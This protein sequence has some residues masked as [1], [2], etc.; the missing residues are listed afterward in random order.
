MAAGRGD[1]VVGGQCRGAASVAPRAPLLC[2]PRV[3]Q[4]SVGR[5]GAHPGGLEQRAALFQ[6][7]GD[8]LARLQLPGGGLR[9]SRSRRHASI[10]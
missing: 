3:D 7:G 2:Q 6:L 9:Q 4:A 8:R 5:V 10:V 1:H